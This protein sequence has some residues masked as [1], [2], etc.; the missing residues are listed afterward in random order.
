MNRERFRRLRR[1]GLLW[2]L[3]GCLLGT[4]APGFPL[5][6][7]IGGL[8]AARAAVD[9]TVEAR[10]TLTVAQGS[11]V[12]FDPGSTL[13]V[14]PGGALELIGASGAEI[15]VGGNGGSYSITVDG[16][17]AAE[18]VNF[19]DLAGPGVHVTANGLIHTVYNFSYCSFLGAGVGGTLL[20]VA[21]DQ[22]FRQGALGPIVFTTWIRGAT[23]N[24]AKPNPGGYLQFVNYTG[25]LSG[26]T[27]ENDPYGLIFWGLFTPTPTASPTPLPTWTPTPLPTWTST[28]LPTW[29]PTPL[30][31]TTPTQAPTPTPTATMVPSPTPCP[32]FR[33]DVDDDGRITTSDALLAF[34]IALALYQPTPCEEFRADADLDGRVITSDALCVFQEALGVPN[35]CFPVEFD[36]PVDLLQ[37]PRVPLMEGEAFGSAQ[38]RLRQGS[39]LDDLGAPGYVSM[40]ESEVSDPE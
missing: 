38:P 15:T 11:S 26:E 6:G 20:T 1:P 13:S 40:T 12:T 34:Q 30:P 24:V 4:P 33:G 16:L 32:G 19:E 10:Y 35:P 7:Q 37:A 25:A 3:L 27:F 18:Y 36:A 5:L 28:P 39:F 17:I 9:C 2:I 23:Y 31:T 22:S 29:T 8:P 21:N 14:A